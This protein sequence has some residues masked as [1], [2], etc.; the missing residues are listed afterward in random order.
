[1]HRNNCETWD[2]MFVPLHLHHSIIA[3]LMVV[4]VGHILMARNNSPV[5]RRNHSRLT[6]QLLPFKKRIDQDARAFLVQTGE[7]DHAEGF[8]PEHDMHA[9]D[10]YP[11][12][13]SVGR[14]ARGFDTVQ[15]G[16]AQP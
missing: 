6:W 5:S 7:L 11:G 16:Y 2:D 12:P 8:E 3:S 14:V 1:M 15:E 4:G 9:L 10:D 13:D